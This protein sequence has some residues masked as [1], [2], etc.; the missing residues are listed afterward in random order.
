[1]DWSAYTELLNELAQA[2]RDAYESA[3]RTTPAHLDAAI[4]LAML[5][6]LNSYMKDNPAPVLSA[7]TPATA[8]SGADDFTL[9]CTGTGFTDRSVIVFG[10]HDEPTTLVSDTEVTTIVKPSLFA[11][12]EVPVWVRNGPSASDS[13]NFTFTEPELPRAA[14]AEHPEPVAEAESEAESGTEDDSEDSSSKRSKHARR[15]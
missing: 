5:Q 12:A 13:V 4:F 8:V 2:R 11:P 9:S 10:S 14:A 3:P 7:L 15:K 6:A 1:M